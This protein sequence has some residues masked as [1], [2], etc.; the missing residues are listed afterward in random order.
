[1]LGR[2]TPK[3]RGRAYII[4]KHSRIAP[5]PMLMSS[6]VIYLVYYTSEVFNSPEE[7]GTDIFDDTQHAEPG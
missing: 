2:E 4:S 7:E 3:L 6:A 5:M 1:V